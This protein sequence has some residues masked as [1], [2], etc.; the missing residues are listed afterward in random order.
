MENLTSVTML[1][2]LYKNKKAYLKV[3]GIIQNPVN[4]RQIPL[5]FESRVDTGFDGGLL[6]PYWH[7][8]NAQSIG[9]EPTLT[10]ITLAGGRKIAAYV[11]VGYIQ[12]I[13]NHTLPDPG[14]PVMLVMCGNRDGSLLGMDA[15]KNQIIAFNGPLQSFT[16]SF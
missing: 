1:T 10:N 15:L 7:V 6:I 8:S 5:N 2:K 4:L 9:I 11:C 13:E 12:M 16:L 14:I 3:K